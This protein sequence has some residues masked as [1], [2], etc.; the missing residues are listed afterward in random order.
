MLI[1]AIVPLPQLVLKYLFGGFLYLG[2]ETTL[3]VVSFLAGIIGFIL[4]AWRWIWSLIK[5]LFRIKTGQ[6]TT[7]AGE[8]GTTNAQDEG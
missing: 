5:R 1:F 6:A 3:P 2:P 7:A 4:V 8:T